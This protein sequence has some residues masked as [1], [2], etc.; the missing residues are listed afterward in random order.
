MF[1][2]ILGFHSQS[3]DFTNAFPHA[4]ISSGLPVLIELPRYLKSDGRQHDV[5]FKLNK[6]LYGQAEAACLWY[7][8]LRNG[9]LER[10][11]VTS[12][13]DTCL[14]MSKTVMCVVYV[15]NF[16]FWERSQSD[17][18]NVMKSFKEY[19]PSYNR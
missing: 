3:I 13:V 2:C 16:T 10:R 5:V 17:I 18:D 19:G 6:S 14:F 8:N 7:E 4:H 1:Q 9:L 12:K 11:F 15:D